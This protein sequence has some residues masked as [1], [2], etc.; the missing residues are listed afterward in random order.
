[1]DDVQEDLIK[2]DWV[3]VKI[4]AVDQDIWHK[5]DRPHGALRLDRILQGVM[6]FARKF[7]GTLVTETMLVHGLNDHK[8]HIKEIADCISC[9]KPEK[10][11]LLAKCVRYISSKRS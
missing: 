7:G 2:A 9:I 6:D 11:Y 1:M 4:D 8:A 3:S 5:I 10:A